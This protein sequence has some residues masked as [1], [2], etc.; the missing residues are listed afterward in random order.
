MTMC[1]GL[2]IISS[3]NLDT[4]IKHSIEVSRA[5]S[6]HP[7]S[8]LSAYANALFTYLAFNNFN[9]VKWP[10]FLMHTIN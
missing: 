1:V 7:S 8:Y 9:L 2:T 3:K 5:I 10:G 6:H 4:I